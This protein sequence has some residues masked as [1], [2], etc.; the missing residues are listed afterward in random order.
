[1]DAIALFTEADELTPNP[2]FDFNIGLA[3]EDLGDTARALSSYR[4]YLR[5]APAAAD[6][7]EVDARIQRL[8]QRLSQRGVQQVTLLSEPAGARIEVDGEPIGVT[9]WTFETS[10]GFHRVVLELNGYE[11]EE[12][13]FDLPPARSI[14]VPITL[15]K[16]KPPVAP[17]PEV[18]PVL[19]PGC[20][21][22]CLDAVSASSWTIAGVGLVS[23][24]VA[25]GFEVHRAG[26]QDASEREPNQVEAARLF[27]D[28]QAAQKWATG[29]GMVGG[30]LL[31]TGTVLGI[32]DI[33]EGRRPRPLAMALNGLD[34]GCA[35][36]GCRLQWSD[37]F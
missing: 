36:G 31:V 35:N 14:D 5:R 37:R 9:P 21:G 8:E 30:T 26:R 19:V 32:I 25:V 10:P 17:A 18:Q 15:T 28:A 34:V 11:V 24:G 3:Y 27:D 22:A 16:L 13:S 1:M 2:A 12:R 33:S 20:T 6:R 7:A 29:F 4:S 23:L